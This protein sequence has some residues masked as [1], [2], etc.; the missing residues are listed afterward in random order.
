MHVDWLFGEFAFGWVLNGREE[1]T[2]AEL[3][4]RT[5]DEA[6]TFFRKLNGLIERETRSGPPFWGS[7]FITEAIYEYFLKLKAAVPKSRR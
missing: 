1:A 7:A 4:G 6:K 3:G 2:L 5:D